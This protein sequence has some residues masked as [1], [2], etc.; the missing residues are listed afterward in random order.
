MDEK[1]LRTLEYDKVLKRLTHYTSFSAG[2]ALATALRPTTD[3]DQA[4]LWQLETQEAKALFES[5]ADV[6][7]G[8][9]RDVRS[10][11]ERSER[12]FTLLTADFM[13]IKSTL[14]AARTLQRKLI[15][16]EEEFPNLADIAYL[17]EECPGIVGAITKTIDEQGEVLD[18]ASPALARIRRDLRVAYNRL[19]D[20]LRALLTSSNNQYLQ[21][22]II[23]SR[24]G[25]YVVPLRAEH[26]GRIK[27]IIHDQSGS[28]ATL[29]IEPLFTVELNNEYRTLQIQ[30]Q[31]EIDRILAALSAEIAVQGEPL[32]RVV[33]RMAELDLIFARARFAMETDAV[34]P[35]F[36]A[37]AQN[38]TAQPQ[39]QSQTRTNCVQPA[40]W[41]NPV[42][43]RLHV[44]RY[45]IRP[46]S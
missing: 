16:L 43:T 12:G 13:D 46:P 11:V 7:I 31:K 20:K 10:A 40:P 27:G 36:V 34:A 39:T 38:Q 4:R 15:R 25:R 35:Q 3:P 32:I 29:W 41:L 1:S 37:L 24:A 6:M 44:I 45:S 26:K 18:S 21:E 30:E 14:I 33:E 2:E 22:P 17:I 19:Q 28:G 23:T 5:G 8:G 42:D 9:T